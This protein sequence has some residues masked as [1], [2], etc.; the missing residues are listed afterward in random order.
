MNRREVFPIL[1]IALFPSLPQVQGWQTPQPDADQ[2]RGTFGGYKQAILQQ[3]G[4][5][6][7]SLI[8][9]ST[10]DY[11]ARMK[12]LAMAG[13]E[14]DVRHLSPINKMMVLS[15]RHRMAAN[16][17]KSMTPEQ[18]FTYAVNDGWIGKNSV[19]DSDI[20]QIKI[21]G[22]DA[23]AEFVKGG[24]ATPLKYRFTK[25]G[26]SWKIDLTALMPLADEA[27]RALIK[28]NGVEEDVFIVALIE[29]VSGRKVPSSIWRPLGN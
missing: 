20:G 23:S 27:M 17:L 26:A 11:Y 25:E 8:N 1:I 19:L 6:A 7:L 4:P 3:Q 10:L 13:A 15:L 9:R 24:K 5:S 16:E 14:K 29:S 12:T 18:V 2:I 28:N 22:N 21:S